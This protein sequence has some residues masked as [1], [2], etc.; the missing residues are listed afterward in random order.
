MTDEEKKAKEA[1]DA[2]AAKEAADA[3]SKKSSDDLAD[4]WLGKP[5]SAPAPKEEDQ[6]PQP[7]PISGRGGIHATLRQAEIEQKLKEKPAEDDE[8][9]EKKA[10]ADAAKAAEGDKPPVKFNLRTRKPADTKPAD[11]KP[12]DTKPAPA[13]AKPEEGALTAEDRTFI[14]TLP[15]ELQESVDFWEEAESVDPEKYKG[16]LS[17]Q[18][19]Y[20]KGYQAEVDRLREEEG[21][22][23]DPETSA[24]LRRWVQKQE[25]PRASFRDQQQVIQKKIQKEIGDR[26]QQKEQQRAAQDKIAQERPKIEK[27]ISDFS[28]DIAAD[29]PGDVLATYTEAMKSEEDSEAALN[30][31]AD[32]HGPSVAEAIRT[33]INSNADLAEAFVGLTRGVEAYDPKNPVHGKTVEKVVEL[34]R[35]MLED[36]KLEPLRTKADGRKFMPRE[37]YYSRETSDEV[38]AKHFT[39]TEDQVLKL[40]GDQAKRNLKTTMESAIEIEKK[41]AERLAKR[42]HGVEPK[43][44][45]DSNASTDDDDTPPSRLVPGTD[46]K[47]SVDSSLISFMSRTAT[48][49]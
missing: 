13:E 20:L 46:S 25:R 5:S 45:S 39:F 35:L 22:D 17:Q 26:E 15:P 8:D 36:P 33:S 43:K 14:A 30:A 37:I 48:D 9:P 10:A 12:A 28:D 34:G 32:E 49:E 11:T 16:K 4:F 38:R 27:L 31:V 41:R 6:A 3:E 47:P 23:F 2:A 29:I 40:L 7:A 21:E 24:D 18:L 44:N 19:N 1:A 42:Y